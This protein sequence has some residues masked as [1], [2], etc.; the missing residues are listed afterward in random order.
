MEPARPV[1]PAAASA[2]A[3]VPPA[4]PKLADSQA[5][6]E[7]S[8]VAIQS[9]PSQGTGAAQFRAGPAPV[10]QQRQTPSPQQGVPAAIASEQSALQRQEG[11][12]RRQ[13]DAS[14]PK[15]GVGGAMPE[16]GQKAQDKL[17]GARGRR[18]APAL[19]APPATP[20]TL[21]YRLQRAEGGDAPPELTVETSSGFVYVLRRTG[22][23]WDTVGSGNGPH[24][25]ADAGEYAV[26]ASRV[27]MA[28]PAS[29]LRGTPTNRNIV[30]LSGDGF[31]SISTPESSVSATVRVR[32]H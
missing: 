14:A 7:S 9:V 27:E 11:T 30:S 8:N 17:A 12:I 23:G 5:K 19:A 13:Q 15:A 4:A 29:V 1:P 10:V 16:A 32:V 20:L 26:V 2:P 3:A 28:N 22:S 24:V 25:V 31:T 18:E 21:R 6:Q